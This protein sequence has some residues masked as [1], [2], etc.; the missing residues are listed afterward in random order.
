MIVW[1]NN[2]I[3]VFCVRNIFLR[4]TKK[5]HDFCLLSSKIHHLYFPSTCQTIT[6]AA[7]E[8]QLSVFYSRLLIM[9]YVRNKNRVVVVEIVLK[10]HVQKRKG[11]Q[12][13][14]LLKWSRIAW[15]KN[16]VHF[17]ICNSSNSWIL[18]YLIGKYDISSKHFYLW[19]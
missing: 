17:S 11:I 3:P 9:C 10:Y 2:Y 8:S 16:K 13:I 6:S 15:G 1:F 19:F 14:S 7:A 4:A 5:L 18:I 12:E